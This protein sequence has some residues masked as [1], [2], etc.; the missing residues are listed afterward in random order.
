MHTLRSTSNFY[1]EFFFPWLLDNQ[2][3]SFFQDTIIF[4]KD[5]NVYTNRLFLY[6][7]FPELESAHSFV[8]CN[9]IEVILADTVETEV[10]NAIN[11]SIYVNANEQKEEAVNINVE[12]H[13]PDYID[14][15]F[16]D[17]L[18]SE[19]DLKSLNAYIAE[20]FMTPKVI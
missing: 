2:S 6:L 19:N 15:T 4:C 17:K 9:T 1:S 18:P 3:K 20:N 5:K 14:S 8:N 16:S 12:I 11:E 13:A 10:I 7:L